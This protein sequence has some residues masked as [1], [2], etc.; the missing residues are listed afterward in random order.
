MNDPERIAALE[1]QL[2]EQALT[3]TALIDAAEARENDQHSALDSW[4]RLAEL[5]TTLNEKA[6][7]LESALK[8][9]ED[10][11]ARQ[12]ASEALLRSTLDSLDAPIVILDEQG[13]VI[14]TNAI[15]GSMLISQ[16]WKERMGIGA[17]YLEHCDASALPEGPT[18][19]GLADAIR[20]VLDA[21]SL[22]QR[23]EYSFDY[24]G[25]PSW[26]NAQATPLTMQDGRRGC[27]VAHLDMTAQRAAEREATKRAKENELLSLVAKYT[28]Q[29][30]VITDAQG[31]M[32]WANEGFTRLT[33]YAQEEALGRPPGKLL[34]GPDSDPEAVRQ[35]REGIESKRGFDVQLVNYHKTGRK[36]WIEM[37]ARPILDE[38]GRLQRFIAVQTEITER[39]RM[40]RQLAEERALL[41]E[42]L[43]AIPFCVYWKDQDS[44]FLGCNQAFAED[45][46]L[47][48]TDTV[49]G[50]RDEDMPGG[51]SEAEDFRDED[52]QVLSSGEP[53]LHKFLTR[54]DESG[55]T[56]Y[57][58]GS[59]VPLLNGDGQT[60]GVIG[61]YTDVTEQKN[62]ELQL[63]QA[64]KLESIGQL[65]AG[66]AHEINTPTQFVGDNTRFLSE[67]FE[68]LSPALVQARDLAKG[69]LDGADTSKSAGELIELL[70]ESDV[71]Y[72]LEEIPA[73][74]QQSMDGISRVAKIVGAMKEFS[75]PGVEGMT[76]IDLNQALQSTITVATNEW[77]YVADVITD[78]DEELPLVPCLP[79]ELNQVVLNIIVNASHAIG[80]VLNKSQAEKGTIRVSTR[81]EGDQVTVRIE[82]SGT[83]IPEE[84]R[85]KIFDPFFTTKEVGRGTGQGLS[86]AH[87]VVVQKHNGTLALESELGV[88]STFIIGLPL[89]PDA[90]STPEAEANAA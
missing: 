55:Q 25:E 10:L 68:E 52:Q 66:I 23:I 38:S 70:E 59:K 11:M 72:L 80:D 75:H 16:Q 60:V 64:N 90:A 39:K 71:E 43:H 63:T 50:L 84:I 14:E 22:S 18:V 36:Y 4:S 56:T 65:A 77:K 40:E 62:I 13:K 69:V 47:E 49:I 48:S 76:A 58:S 41:N 88:G 15:W 57:L 74:L 78:F 5:N 45:N 21:Q 27:V 44:R 3:I 85:A 81:H 37:E 83:G 20:S 89:H 7:E 8:R 35:M 24:S 73:A 31:R 28:D 61:I 2:E 12:R 6:R 79:G 19:P 32:L 34:Q 54:E 1:A 87:N 42:I 17:N 29:S 26:F 82:D 53:I 67:S 46:G 51:C 86:I 9:N 30:V 33:G